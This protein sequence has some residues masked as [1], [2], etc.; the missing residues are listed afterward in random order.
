M[1]I[2]EIPINQLKIDEES[3]RLNL[4]RKDVEFN[5][6]LYAISYFGLQYPL[7]VDKENNVVCGNQ[8]FK[9]LKFLNYEKVPCLVTNVSKDKH[10]MLKISM[11]RIRGNWSIY[12]LQ[13]FFKNKKLTDEEVKVLGFKKPEINCLANLDKF[14]NITLKDNNHKQGDLF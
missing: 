14:E 2:V 7:I 10:W 13:E 5:D 6:L 1:K 9:I 12:R 3:V 4:T 11:N 8:V